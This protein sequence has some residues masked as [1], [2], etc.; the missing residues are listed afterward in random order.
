MDAGGI[1]WIFHVTTL[2]KDYATNT[3]WAVDDYPGR[4]LTA[5]QWYEYMNS[6]AARGAKLRLFI[7]DPKRFAPSIGDYDRLTLGLDLS[8]EEDFYQHYFKDL[9][10]WFR[11]KKDRDFLP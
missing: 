9:M 7:T 10:K 8:K 6:Q 3:W 1:E 11:S 5:D 4:I 2:V